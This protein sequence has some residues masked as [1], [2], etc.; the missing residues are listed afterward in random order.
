MILVRIEKQWYRTWFLFHINPDIK[1]I[2]DAIYNSDNNRWIKC[3]HTSIK[4]AFEMDIWMNGIEQFPFINSKDII[5][6]H[7]IAW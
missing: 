4:A 6:E 3:K 7:W 1:G 5:N 2:S